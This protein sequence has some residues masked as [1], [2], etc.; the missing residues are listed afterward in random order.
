MKSIQILSQRIRP[1]SWI[2]EIHSDMD[3]DIIW[4][5]QQQQQKHSEFESIRYFET[6]QGD[7]HECHSGKSDHRPANI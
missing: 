6:I 2:D 3:F 1:K 5:Q 7:I 4:L